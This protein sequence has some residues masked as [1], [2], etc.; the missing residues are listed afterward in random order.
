VAQVTAEGVRALKRCK[1]LEEIELGRDPDI[2]QG[3]GETSFDS[4]V[5]PGV[6]Q[7]RSTPVTG[8]RL[9]SFRQGFV[10]KGVVT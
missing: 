3:G 7:K 1:G 9:D 4:K 2:T 5:R 6:L 10:K 8:W